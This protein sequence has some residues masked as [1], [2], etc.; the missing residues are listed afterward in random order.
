MVR[1]IKDGTVASIKPRI[2]CIAFTTGYGENTS[3]AWTFFTHHIGF[4]TVGEA[5]RELAQE[6]LARYRARGI[7]SL[8]E[9]E[10]TETDKIDPARFIAFVNS[11]FRGG[12]GDYGDPDQAGDTATRWWPFTDMVD[13]LDYK[14]GELVTIQMLG[15]EVILAAI[16]K[17]LLCDFDAR[18]IVDNLNKIANEL[19]ITCRREPDPNV[20]SIGVA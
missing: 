2:H 12:W 5:L 1:K 4:E 6:L 15:A 20:L 8:D 13:I 16:D 7:K 3:I 11:L 17:N 10:P 14:R 9:N 19:G 18:E